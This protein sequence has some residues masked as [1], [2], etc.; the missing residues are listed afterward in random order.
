MELLDY[1]IN[2]LRRSYRKKY[3]NY[4][5]SR[6]MHR[7]NDEANDIQIITQQYIKRP[8][9]WA[10]T[11]LYL[12]QFRMH[13]EVDEPFHE[14]NKE[15]DEQRELDVIDATNGH[16]FRRI[17]IA[18]AQN[19]YRLLNQ[20]IDNIIEEILD[21]RLSMQDFVP[22]NVGDEFN[23]EKFSESGILDADDRPKFR[24][25]VDAANFLGQDIKGM[26]RAFFSSKKY[27]G[28]KFWFPKFYKNELW[29]NKLVDDQ[30]LLSVHSL[31]YGDLIQEKTTD[32]KEVLRH[33][34]NLKDEKEKRIVFPR[35]K[36]RGCKL[37]CVR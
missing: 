15:L 35:F 6:I 30:E 7:L 31:N 22:W 20:Q 14:N 21:L 17:N 25:I 28:Y 37:N 2:Q 18:A 4:V 27:S 1:N 8:D 19:N 3:E 11:D 26:Q 29:D 12:P 16:H 32:K 34:N 36:D 33:Y 13:I 23:M 5:V 10:L 24:T 9:R